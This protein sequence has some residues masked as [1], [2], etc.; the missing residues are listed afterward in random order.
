MAK[1]GTWITV[2]AVILLL[3][4]AASL[5][6]F[7]RP[8]AGNTAEIYVDGALYR[9]VELG[10]I[11]A[12]ERIEVRTERGVNV[13]LAEPGLERTDDI[14]AYLLQCIRYRR[15]C[16]CG[17]QADIHHVDA[18]GMGA[19]RRYVDD[20]CLRVAALCRKHHTIAHQKGWE[21][22]ARDYKVY[23]IERYR[24]DM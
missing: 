2:I 23:G 9:R 12:P 19:D 22:F 10:R 16:I 18:I 5:F 8:A 24:T 15:C 1:T 6:L 17:Q 7:L 11:T 14:D 4:V 21:S 20:S 3:S 13:I